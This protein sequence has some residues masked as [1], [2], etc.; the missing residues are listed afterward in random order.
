MTRRVPEPEEGRLALLQ[1]ALSSLGKEHYSARNRALLLLAIVAFFLAWNTWAVLADRRPS[2]NGDSITTQVLQHVHLGESILT[3]GKVKPPVAGV[4]TLGLYWLIGNAMLSARILSTL[5]G[6][7]LLVQIFF[8]G[9]RL[10]GSDKAGLASALV[11]GCL[12]TVFGWTRLDY[13]EILLSC[14]VVGALELMLRVRLDRVLPAVGLGVV[15]G[16]GLLTHLAFAVYVAGPAIWF[17]A[18]RLRSLRSLLLL[19]LVA[20]SMLALFGPWAIAVASGLGRVASGSYHDNRLL[21]AFEAYVHTLL[22]FAPL[23]VLAA[24]GALW[25][26][27]DRAR[28]VDR[29]AR[30]LVFS[31]GVS[32]LLL[33]GFV[34]PWSRYAIPLYPF[35]AAIVGAAAARITRRL[36]L[37]LRAP[38]HLALGLALLASFA[39]TSL[40]D[41]APGREQRDGMLAPDRRPYVAANKVGA[42]LLAR[43]GGQVLMVFNSPEALDS[44]HDT[45]AVGLIW[46]ERGLQVSVPAPIAPN[47]DH[48]RLFRTA[49]LVTQPRGRSWSTTKYGKDQEVWLNWVRRRS[50]RL[51]AQAQDPDGL[52]YSGYLMD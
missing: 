22:D 15:L 32:L 33:L 11:L 27:L 40:G 8:F 16:L 23:F 10:G 19:A 20:A 34:M 30:G 17:V 21:A 29:E 4:L 26:L 41:P 5:A 3:V 37:A 1:R 9:R 51:V 18:K 39:L 12:P 52:V 43:R 47:E 35:A 45:A 24:L 46:R 28:P 6:A 50:V 31:L 13:R 2:V 14:F 25:L 36:P 7:F 38:V 44:L 42:A 48:R 49:I